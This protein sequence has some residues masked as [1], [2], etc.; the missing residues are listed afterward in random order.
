M[1]YSLQS[2]PDFPESELD[3]VASAISLVRNM[4]FEARLTVL[5]KE[6]SFSRPR[7]QNINSKS[8]VSFGVS[9]GRAG[10]LEVADLLANDSIGTLFPKKTS[11]SGTAVFKRLMASTSSKST[12]PMKQALY[13]TVPAIEP[14]NQSI[15]P[16]RTDVQPVQCL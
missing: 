8:S 16:Q 1:Q 4:L 2:C 3:V 15:A 11:F 14:R 9:L 12:L 10:G 13:L 6:P 7:K 5:R